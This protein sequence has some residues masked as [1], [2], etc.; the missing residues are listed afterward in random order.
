MAGRFDD[1]VVQSVRDAAD[2]VEIAGEMTRLKRAGKRY[3]GLCPFHKEKTPSFSVDPTQGLYYCFGCG[4]GGDAI[5]LYQE[6]TGDDF[7]AAIEALARRY[8]IPLPEP[9]TRPDA[10]E[11]RELGSV[12]EAAEKFFRDQLTRSDFARGYLDKRRIP[13]DLR[14]RYGLGYAPDGWRHLLQSLGRRFPPRDLLDAGLVAKSERTGELYDRFRHRLVFPIHGPSGRLV[15]F[16]GR[17]LGDDRAKYVN[18]AETDQFHKGNLLYGFHLA[19][20]EIRDGGRALLVEG[21]FDVVGAAASG[22]GWVVAGMG[23]ALTSTQARLLARYCDDVIVGYD[24]DDAG[25]TALRRALPLLLAAGVGVRRAL[26]PAGHDPDSL[27]LAEGPE[28]VTSAVDAAV[29]AVE[30][31]LERLAPPAAD[32]DPRANAR[33]ADRIAD[34]LRPIRDR[35][36]L[37]NYGRRAAERLGIPLDMLWRRAGRRR[38]R[39]TD[40]DGPAPDEGTKP[41]PRRTGGEAQ[42]MA[43]LLRPGA[44]VPPPEEL[45]PEDVFFDA[46]WR[47]VYAAF[48]TLYRDGEPRRPPT[49]AAVIA[50][51][52]REDA[53]D[54]VAALVLDDPESAEEDAPDADVGEALDLLLRRWRKQ[55]GPAL[56]R[57]IRQASEQ[58]DQERLARLLEEKKSLSRS[59]HPGMTG[60]LW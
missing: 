28:A 11:R 4:A 23:T 20:R 8:G 30:T 9:S 48:C 16:G 37:H 46:D 5:K 26:F 18:T 52:G 47:S 21:Y 15:G 51:L 10:G 44:A 31:E 57:E 14:A 13:A 7:P 2:V 34:L 54:R 1:R 39:P 41:P 35:V 12:L 59:L 49:A 29:D 25:E 24:G 55:R 43:L 27:R 60:K 33:A 56:L 19:K 42:T 6:H 40:L 22:I 38:G 3:Q 58:G 17:T 53:L 45:P 50:H 36:V 32:L